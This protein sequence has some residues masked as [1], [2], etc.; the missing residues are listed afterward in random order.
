MKA[1]KGGGGKSEWMFLT[2]IDYTVAG[3]SGTNGS[4]CFVL[5]FA[6]PHFSPPLPSG[7]QISK[8]NTHRIFDPINNLTPVLHIKSDIKI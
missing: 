7:V 6:L 4:V 1:W 5:K 3:Y 8:Q 2:H